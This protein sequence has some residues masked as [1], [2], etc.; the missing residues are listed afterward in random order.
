MSRWPHGSPQC[1]LC[2]RLCVPLS[3]IS[4]S[5]SVF[6]L[7]IL[8]LH[9]LYHK[10]QQALV[11]VHPTRN[12]ATSPYNTIRINRLWLVILFTE[13]TRFNEINMNKHWALGNWTSCGLEVMRINAFLRMNWHFIFGHNRPWLMI[14]LKLWCSF[15]RVVIV[16][17]S[18]IGSC[19]YRLTN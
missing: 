10:P 4:T 18:W 14:R 9:S 3:A 2:C 8:S 15:K 7:W 12:S 13:C 6:F 11:I 16:P 5:F 17:R 1:M 19:V